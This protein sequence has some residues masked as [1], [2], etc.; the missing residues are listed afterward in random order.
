MTAPIG[1]ALAAHS[2]DP[3]PLPERPALTATAGFTGLGFSLRQLRGWLGEGN[4]LSQLH[5]ALERHRIVVAEL[6]GL[7]AEERPQ[8]QEDVAFELAADL[9]VR[10]LTVLPPRE[11]ALSG[12]VA[13]LRRLHGKATDIGATVEFEPLPWTIVADPTTA[14]WLVRLAGTGLCL[15]VWHHF[16]HGGTLA[17]LTGCWPAVTTVQLSDGTSASGVEDPIRDCL[18][19]RQPLGEGRF[20]LREVLALVPTA[21]LSVE[22]LSDRL[23]ALPPE[24]A[25][26][27]I[28]ES[29][30]ALLTET[31]I[32]RSA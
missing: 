23:R 11:G 18:N 1:A 25:A 22:V 10:H 8:P 32:T 30:R 9:G 28:G 12:V 16:R 20:P 3:V 17:E 31:A 19:N 4:R 29:A 26:V 13:G 6:E 7:V 2:L 21:R 15:D 24:A 27:T 14:Q 5:A